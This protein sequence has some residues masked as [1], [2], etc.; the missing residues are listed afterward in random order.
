MTIIFVTFCG[1]GYGIAVQLRRGLGRG[2]APPQ[3]KYNAIQ[4]KLLTS[5]KDTVRNLVYSCACAPTQ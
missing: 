3:K 1:N 4:V 5:R 2:L